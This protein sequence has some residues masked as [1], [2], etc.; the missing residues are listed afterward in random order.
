M[1][2][3][4]Q[5]S[6][7]LFLFFTLSLQAQ[8]DIELQQVASG[9]SSPVDITHAGDERLFIVER[10]GRIKIMDCDRTVLSEPFL[11][12]DNKVTPTSGQ[13]EQGLLGLA[14]HPDFQN[15]GY[16]F[17]HYTANTEDGVIARYSVNPSNPNIADPD[18]EEIILNIDQPTWNHN[19]G[20]LK[21]GPDGYLYIGLGDGGFANDPGNRAQNRQNFLGKM[22]RLD[23]DNGTPYS[24]PESNPFA[25]DDETLDEIWAIGLRNPWRFSFDKET[26]DLWIGDVGQGQ[27]EEI[28]F[29][30][31]DSPGG[32]NYGWRC[33]EGN[34]NFNTSGCN[35]IG[36][37]VGAIAEYNHQGFTHC[38]VTG[39]FV[40][41][42]AKFPSLVG[43]YLY[44]DYC[45]GRFWATSAD[46]SG[47]WNTE[48]L[49][50][51]PGYGISTFGEDI[52]GEMYAASLGQGR[53]Y[54]VHA[55]GVEVNDV[56]DG[57]NSEN[58][59]ITAPE[60]YCDYH[61]YQDGALVENVSGN[62]FETQAIGDYYVIAY[63]DSHF[64]YTS[65]TISITTNTQELESLRQI[66][67]SPNPF[68]DKLVLQLES[69][70]PL[71]V[72]ILILDVQGKQV[73]EKAVELRG[74]H[75][76][77]LSLKDLEAGIYMMH[78]QTDEGEVIRK[79]VKQK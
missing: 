55:A 1:N 58:G 39:G 49:G 18:S 78:L 43:Q 44:V 63:D 12:I 20:C 28:N 30:A 5:F 57:V 3:N 79:I 23:V 60:G 68:I 6:I 16:F 41:R 72:N 52:N 67:L 13:N 9:F 35:G 54:R 17:V 26:G 45:S 75:S 65:A 19:G 2:L 32:E 51:F 34:H 69:T 47:G 31:A 71:D 46:G 77:T 74:Q 4:N 29:Q 27:W 33:Y 62:I 50:S 8:L 15:N 73:F 14:F 21:F 36:E 22:L 53:I 66:Q 61:W 76:E 59:I 7:F 40:Y 37:Y 24:I 25:V 10:S 56:L 38:S 48:Q 11:D 64:D 42:G 70:Q